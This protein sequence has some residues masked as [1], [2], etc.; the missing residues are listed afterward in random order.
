MRSARPGAVSA[1]DGT[2][3]RGLSPGPVLLHSVPGAPPHLEAAQR[4]TQLLEGVVNLLAGGCQLLCVYSCWERPAGTCLP[5]L[6]L[7]VLSRALLPAAMA[8]GDASVKARLCQRE[9]LS[10]LMGL[11]QH[12]APPQQLRVL[13]CVRQLCT[14]QAVLQPLEDAGAV[15]YVVAQL[16]GQH[17]ALQ[18]DALG[19]L[20]SLCQLSRT[21]QEQAA[22]Q[23][24]AAPLVAL[25]QQ[26][27]PQAAGADDGGA[28][29]AAAWAASRCLAVSLLCGFGEP[30]LATPL[31]CWEAWHQ[32]VQPMQAAPRPPPLCSARRR[33]EP[34]GAVGGRRL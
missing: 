8:Y 29:A 28:A 2:P 31:C 18:A 1:A 26:H 32:S 23:R 33:A 30:A 7:C 21:R 22:E 6:T 15:T 25:V 34:A 24:A 10:G 4:L 5:L 12:M 11:A 20:H 17:P 13:R 16:H 3:D 9:V 19:A 14:E 27:A